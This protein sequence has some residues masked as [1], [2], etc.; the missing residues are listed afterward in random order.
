MHVHLEFANYR[1]KKKENKT[2]GFIHNFSFYKNGKHLDYIT[3]ESAVYI[4]EDEIKKNNLIIEFGEKQSSFKNFLNSKTLLN[5]KQQNNN[6]NKTGLYRLFANEPIDIPITN[7]KKLLNKISNKQNIWEM[8]I[9]PGELGVK[10]FCIDKYDWNKLLNV[11]LKKLF[12]FNNVNSENII[13]HWVIHANTDFPHIH[14]SFWEKTSNINNS[15]RKKGTFKKGTLERFAWLLENN[16]ER[17]GEYQKIY[18][19]KNEIWSSRK[20]L[21]TLFELNAQYNFIKNSVEIIKNFYTNSKNQNYASSDKSL[22]VHN[23]VWNI[24]D[25]V[26]ETNSEFKEQYEKYKNELKI[27]ESTKFKSNYNS[28]LAKEFIQKE[29]IEFEKQLGNMI[30]KACLKYEIPNLNTFILEE[31]KNIKHLLKK[32]KFD[33]DRLQFYKKINA[34]KQFNKN[35]KYKGLAK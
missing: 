32:W 5:Y 21:K 29:S 18:D 4:Q 23:A 35:I 14:L 16:I 34:I 31:N 1:T 7:E 8:I 12:R 26:K 22:I 11:N 20:K 2:T 24:F 33:F 19:D 9:N 13:G 3:R 10:N 25:F 27:L 6:T 30:V 28:S 15:F 17:D